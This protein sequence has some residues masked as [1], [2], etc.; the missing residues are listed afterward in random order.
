MD[1][2]YAC[3]NL[4][5]DHDDS[6]NTNPNQAYD[7]ESTANICKAACMAKDDGGLRILSSRASRDTADVQDLLGL[8][9]RSQSLDGLM[10]R[11][12]KIAWA[13]EEHHTEAYAS[14][15]RRVLSSLASV[16]SFGQANGD[17][18]SAKR[19]LVPALMVVVAPEEE[20]REI[21]VDP[22][23]IVLI[24]KPSPSSVHDKR[25]DNVLA[26]L[27]NKHESA[28]DSARARHKPMGRHVAVSHASGE[29]ISTDATFKR[30]SSWANHALGFMPGRSDRGRVG[31]DAALGPVDIAAAL[32]RGVVFAAFDHGGIAVLPAVDVSRGCAWKLAPLVKPPACPQRRPLAS[33]TY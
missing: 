3:S 22:A 4:D 14:V 23:V 18:S 1:M 13:E 24:Q 15:L 5:G 21:V 11:I 7:L 30:R 10:Q 6:E 9:V 20:L 17:E 25:F 33:L 29:I 26:N 28:P 2:E 8:D 12:M 16:Q 31:A 32:D 19:T 27:C